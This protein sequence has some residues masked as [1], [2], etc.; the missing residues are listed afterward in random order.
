MTLSWASVSVCYFRV[1]RGGVGAVV[2]GVKGHMFSRA[3]RTMWQHFFLSHTLTL[4]LCDLR[5][6]CWHQNGNQLLCWWRTA[7]RRN[8]PP[9][10]RGL[11]LVLLSAVYTDRPST[12]QRGRSDCL[13]AGALT[14]F[15]S[16]QQKHDRKWERKVFCCILLLQEHK[17]TLYI[18]L[19]HF[20]TVSFRI[21]L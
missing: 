9:R 6:L 16:K 13:S 18:F 19:L 5:P 21:K 4:P 7:Q 15:H 11:N 10:W 3:E 8:E 1:C 12:E 2:T 14:L 17:W 20:P